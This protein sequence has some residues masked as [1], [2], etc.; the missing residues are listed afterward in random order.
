MISATAADS[1]TLLGLKDRRMVFT[2]VE[3][4][5]QETDFEHRL[6]KDQWWMRLRPLLRILAKHDSTYETEAFAVTDVEN[7]LD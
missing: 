5:A 1:A 7:E 6:P 4:L 2:P 3:E